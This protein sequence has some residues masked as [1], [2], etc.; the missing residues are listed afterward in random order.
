MSIGIRPSQND[1]HKT[2]TG[3]AVRLD[4]W[5]AIF[6]RTNRIISG[7]Q[8]RVQVLG[9]GIPTGYQNVPGWSDGETITFNGPFL[10]DTLRKHDAVGA[11]LRLKG[12]NYHEMSH[13]LFTPRSHDE[14]TRR[15]K[16]RQLSDSKWWYAFNALE[17]QRIETW[18]SGLYGPSKRYFE[19]AV[20]TWLLENGGAT[21]A[22]L[23]HGRKYLQPKI[24]VNAG[25]VFEA[26]YGKDLHDEL[27]SIIDE[28][29]TVD[30]MTNTVKALSLIGRYVA[31][32]HRIEQAGGAAPV[33]IVGDAAHVTNGDTS[34]CTSVKVGRVASKQTQKEAQQQAKANTKKADEADKAEADKQRAEKGEPQKSEDADK[35][36]EDGSGPQE[37]EGEQEGEQSGGQSAPGQGESA[38][39][40]GDDPFGDAGGEGAEAKQPSQSSKAAGMD[41]TGDH[42]TD[43]PEDPTSAMDELMEAAG[44]GL[45]DIETDVQIVDDANRVMVAVKQIEQAGRN[46]AKGSLVKRTGTR[47]PSADE[48]KAVSRITQTLTKIR[49]EVEPQILRRQM[50]GRLDIQRVLTRRPNDMEV[51]TAYDEGSEELTGME[52]VLLVDVSGSMQ[53]SMNDASGSIWVL[54][55]ALDRLGIRTTALAYDTHHYVVYQPSEK[56]KAQVPLLAALGGTVPESALKQ[57]HLIL[58]RS[59]QPNKVLVTVTDG[60]W[61]AVDDVYAGLLRSMHNA[62]V[63]S[64][65]VGLDGAVASYGKHGHLIGHDMESIRSLPK[66]V[67]KLVAQIMKNA[68]GL[69]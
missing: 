9:V 3:I 39:E 8:V 51:F 32:L 20:L 61:G 38:G 15:V 42:A 50:A 19:A 64:M 30:P 2:S 4:A 59:N 47:Q 36:D 16:E 45:E 58:T 26:Q 28:Y 44:E 33:P 24:R 17:D 49:L 43:T 22:M 46:D 1:E 13:V 53:G 31:L 21:A 65:I 25:R 6:E 14:V 35:A 11:V 56:A 34:D 52:V 37:G 60:S 69:Y 57:A 48:L 68:S 23:L 41:G 29:V 10:L 62:G 18:F 7:E 12:L 54:K 66:A 5:R 27:R 40:G 63:T 55:R 67:T